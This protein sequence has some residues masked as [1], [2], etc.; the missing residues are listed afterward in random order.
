MSVAT[1]APKSVATV[2]RPLSSAEFVGMV[3][4]GII[5]ERERVELIE[6]V[7]YAMSPIGPRHSGFLIAPIDILAPHAT[8]RLL[9]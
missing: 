4:A 2:P 9:E 8:G 3:E 7:I 5:G 1:L 6:G